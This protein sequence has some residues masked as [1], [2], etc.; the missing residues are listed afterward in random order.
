MQLTHELVVHQHALEKEVG[1][2][3][4]EDR[5]DGGIDLKC[6]RA[7]CHDIQQQSLLE[8]RCHQTSESIPDI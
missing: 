2:S 3:S 8:V 1:T 4:E 5:S 7:I 6:V